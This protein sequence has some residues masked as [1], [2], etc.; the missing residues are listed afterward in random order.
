MAELGEMTDNRNMISHTC[1]PA[2]V[3]KNITK[4]IHTILELTQPKQ[5][6]WF[7]SRVHGTAHRYADYDIALAG[8]ELD[9][10]AERHLKEALDDKLGIYTVDLIDIEKVD[11]EFK[12][13]IVQ[14]G[15]VVYEH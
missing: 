1:S 11:P 15:V 10:R 3:E 9:H 2:E 13:R 5:I 14:S 4:I 8:A 6:I 12:A 7:G